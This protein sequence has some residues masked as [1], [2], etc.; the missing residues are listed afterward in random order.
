MQL[1]GEIEV[2]K[3]I[4]NAM[5][6]LDS[7]RPHE[8][9]I[10]WFGDGISPGAMLVAATRDET[11]WRLMPKRLY[12]VNDGGGL[13]ASLAPSPEEVEALAS[14]YASGTYDETR[15][16][17]EWRD[18]EGGSGKML[19]H[20]PSIAPLERN[21]ITVDSWEE[22]KVWASRVRREGFSWFRGHGD[23]RFSLS[24][25]LH[26]AGRYRLERYCNEHLVQ[27]VSHAETVLKTRFSL[28]DG[29]DYSTILGLAQHHGLPTPMLDWT[30]SPYVA[31]FFAFSD[32]LENSANREKATHVRIYGL[33]QSFVDQTS[34]NVVVLPRPGPYVASLSIA[35]RHNPRLYAQQ[36]RFLVTNVGDLERY[37]HSIEMAATMKFLT[38]I[39][40]PIAYAVE[41]IDDLRY[42]G[43]TAANLFP[44]LDGVCRMLKHSMRAH[45]SPLGPHVSCLFKE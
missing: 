17:G 32:A 15:I 8:A 11:T 34:P 7:D 1:F 43:L 12:R 19:F 36:G 33:S 24:T 16:A 41:A 6:C 3:G 9:M 45:L 13:V 37:I 28:S 22:F 29:D 35:A 18:S 10:S 38:S 2:A 25:T 26:R 40:V 20:G 23:C 39:R 14:L 42:M 5:L 27:F 4:A 21:E 44:G 30:D 31:A